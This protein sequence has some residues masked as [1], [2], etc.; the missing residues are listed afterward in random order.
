MRRRFRLS[1]R[2]TDVYSSPSEKQRALII[3]VGPH[4]MRGWV[5]AILALED[6][7]FLSKPISEEEFKLAGRCE[8]TMM[9]V[10]DMKAQPIIYSA[11]LKT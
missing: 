3:A 11:D 10:E 8:V 5:Q 2:C 1:F 4:P 9:E 7:G 6:G